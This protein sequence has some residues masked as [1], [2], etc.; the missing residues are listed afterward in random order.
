VLRAV[1]LLFLFAGTALAQFGPAPDKPNAIL[2][3]A[4]P[5][6]VDPNFRETVVLVTQARDSSTVGVILNRPTTQ[7][8]GDLM[9]RA[10][11]AEK[12]AEPV[13]FGGPVMRQVVVA[14]FRSDAA[15]KAAAFHVLHDVY[16][17][18]HPA[19][20]EPLLGGASAHYRLYAGFSG[21]APRQLES[22]LERDSWY[23]LPAS[24]ELVFRKDTSGLWMELLE[25][26]RGSRTEIL[27]RISPSFPG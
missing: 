4:K 21:W 26:A 14:L 15:P 9:P 12:Y 6:L 27:P 7:K 23:V 11:G 1:L 5:T 19:N 8:L 13:Y 22:E 24:E 16:L 17:S 25:K 18:M 10:P 20:V 2:L 3:V